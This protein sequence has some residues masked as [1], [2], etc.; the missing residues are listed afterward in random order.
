M[1]KKSLEKKV[2]PNETWKLLDKKNLHR[3]KLN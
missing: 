2:V 1:T 3:L